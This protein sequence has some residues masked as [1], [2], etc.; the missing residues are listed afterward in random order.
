MSGTQEQKT[1]TATRDTSIPTNG[2]MQLQVVD[3]WDCGASID[4]TLSSKKS[5]SVEDFGKPC[6]S[7]VLESSGLEHVLIKCDGCEA[8][9]DKMIR[10]EE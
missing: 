9:Y 10:N 2:P 3:C 5:W 7:E 4:E 8:S 6:L 1:T